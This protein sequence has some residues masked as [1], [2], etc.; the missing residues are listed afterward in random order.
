MRRY[1]RNCIICR[2]SKIPR[3]AKVGY[4]ALLDISQHHQQDITVDFIT[5]LLEVEGKDAVYIVVNRLTKKCHIIVINYRIGAREFTRFFI[6]HIYRL[7]KL[8]RSIIS[9][10]G[11]Q[12][13]NKFWSYVYKILGITH[14]LL[15]AYHSE[16]DR[17]TE[18]V[19]VIFE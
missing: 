8:P 7:Y 11:T 9:D 14:T 17:Q 12:F 19:N 6:D 1:V 10:R 18:R 16:T 5:E 3:I 2:I 4:L 15:T 13:I